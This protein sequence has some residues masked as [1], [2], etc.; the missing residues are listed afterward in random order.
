MVAERMRGAI[1]LGLLLGFALRNVRRNTARSALSLAAIAAGVAGLIVSGG[2]V[3][4]LIFQLGEAVIHSQSGHIQVARSGYFVSGSRSPGRYLV[5]PEDVARLELATLPHVASSM[6]RLAFSGLVGNGRSSYPVI[7]E[8]IEP[9]AEAKLGTS[10]VLVQGRALT[11][12][13]RYGALV[14]HGVAR[15]M[16]LKPGS[17]FNVVAPTVDEAMNTLELEVVGTF[18]SFSKDYDDRAIKIPLGAAQ[19]LLDTK[20]ANVVVLLLGETR[21]TGAAAAGLAE[22]AG[23]LGLEVRTWD[24]LNDF[25]AKTV[26]LYDRQFGVLRMIV[27]LMVV[28]AVAGAINMGVLERA[29]EFGTMRALGNRSGDVMRLIIVEGALLGVVGAALGMALGCT[30][31]W[32]LSEIGISMPPPP[33]SNLE[34]VARIRLSSGVITG[35]IAVGVV[36][37]VMAS[38]VPALRVTRAPIV[39]NLRQLV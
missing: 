36:A 25:Y 3:N 14:G 17:L 10:L 6:R 16:G 5:A 1:P 27:L 30:A 37:T 33:N 8:G 34:F 20:G 22:K 31:A 4:D 21:N 19:E 39:E 13:D 38:F 26:A 11:S 35:A 18:Q 32:V 24:W 23:T 9:D 12:G 28:L 29:G 7:G 2:F 15:A